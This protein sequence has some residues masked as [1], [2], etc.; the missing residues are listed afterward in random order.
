MPIYHWYLVPLVYTLT[1][2]AGP[3]ASSVVSYVERLVPSIAG[4]VLAFGLAVALSGTGIW[5]EW[6]SA[7]DWVRSRPHAGEQLYNDVARWL[8]T[9]TPANASV[10]YL[11]IGRIGYYSDRRIIDQMG[12]V[13]PEAIEQVKRRN[14]TWVLHAFKPDYYLV[15]SAFTWAGAPLDEPW[16]QAAYEPATSFYRREFNVTLTVYRLRDASAIPSA[17]TVQ[18]IQAKAKDVIGEILAGV[19]HAQTF[20]APEDGLTAV[21]TQMATFARPNSGPLRVRIEQLQPPQVLFEQDFDMAEVADNQWRT[22]RFEP[23]AA[24]AGRTYRISF[25]APSASPGNAVTVWYEP[26]DRYAEGQRFV[27]GQPADGDWTLRLTYRR[28]ER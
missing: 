28:E 3:G 9:N 5:A 4:R 6:R 12:L 26:R 17:P 24:S 2:V 7:R 20:V 8:A 18:A 27:G 19:R 13:T 21:A 22:F 16:F 10:A 25:D 1:L 23:V 14:L 11:E 15:H